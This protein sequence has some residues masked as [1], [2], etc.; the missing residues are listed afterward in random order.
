MDY[1]TFPCSYRGKTYWVALYTHIYTYTDIHTHTLTHNHRVIL[2]KLKDITFCQFSTFEK[3][4]KR[5]SYHNQILL[6]FI[7]HGHG[8]EQNWER[9]IND[10]LIILI[11]FFY[12]I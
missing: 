12:K 1:Y 2:K 10:T 8:V 9:G 6:K 11:F 4:V 5:V 3:R 7:S